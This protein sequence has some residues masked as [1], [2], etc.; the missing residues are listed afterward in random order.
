MSEFTPV[1]AIIGGALIGLAAVLMMLNT[2]RITGIS[3]ITAGLLTPPAEGRLWRGAFIIGLI[4][5]PWL[6]LPA[7]GILPHITVSASD[8][9]LVVAGLMV[10][11]GT[12][13]GAGCTSGH[14]VCGLA[15]LS[16]RSIAATACFMLTG[17]LTV[18][19]VR[20]GGLG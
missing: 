19:I 10:G 16:A 6:Y 5:A 9:M 2:G 8:P 3:S 4:S 17:M 13:L 12:R 20:H 15:R 18:F 1:S 7:G 11:F 14:G